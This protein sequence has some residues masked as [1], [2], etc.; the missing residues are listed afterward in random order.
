[1]QT[2]SFLQALIRSASKLATHSDSYLAHFLQ[3]SWCAIN[4]PVKHSSLA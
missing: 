1:M 3:T 4:M 2:G